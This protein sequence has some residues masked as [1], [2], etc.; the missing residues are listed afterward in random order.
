MLFSLCVSKKTEKSC[1]KKRGHTF[2]S[3]NRKHFP[4]VF[5]SIHKASS[6]HL[7]SF[8]YPLRENSTAAHSVSKRLV[9]LESAC[10]P[11]YTHPIFSSWTRATAMI[12]PNQHVKLLFSVG[13]IRT[14][15]FQFFSCY[16]SDQQII[17]KFLNYDGTTS[18]FLRLRGAL[19]H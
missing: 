14:C 5:P 11:C 10:D 6:T 18:R 9:E 2:S 3:F 19:R 15:A 1:L 7:A 16:L 17:S 8:R 13:V 12:G 4:E